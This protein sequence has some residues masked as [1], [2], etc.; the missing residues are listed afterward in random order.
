MNIKTSNG[1]DVTLFNNGGYQ[2]SHK[3]ELV[4]LNLEQSLI[5]KEKPTLFYGG[6]GQLMGNIQEVTTQQQFLNADWTGIDPERFKK[7]Q[8]WVNRDA[9]CGMM[10]ASVLLAYYQDY[11][12]QEI[13]LDTIRSKGSSS[14]Q[15]LYP[16]LL[17][18]ITSF[19][20]KGTI[21]Y[22]V[23]MGINRFL[24]KHNTNQYYRARGSLTPT[25]GIVMN[26][27]SQPI[28]KPVIVGT[29]QL[30][31]SPDNYKNHWVLAYR[32]TK[33]DNQK[34]YQVHD[35]HGRYNAIINARWTIGL[36]RLLKK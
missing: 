30:L 17:K 8:H 5:F 32:T 33:L 16:S 9:T 29:N 2:I 19:S 23:S 20:P 24:R 14:Y 4:E 28:P 25:Y 36:V 1:Y 3:K 35:N 11:I 15:Q 34:F 7:Y 10:S 12:Q 26:K 21:A 6:P 27:L 22:D 18:E 31:G 13:V